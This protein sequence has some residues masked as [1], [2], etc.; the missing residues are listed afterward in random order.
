MRRRKNRVDSNT[1]AIRSAVQK[2]GAIWIDLTGDG[3]VGFD[4]LIAFR[5]NTWL[6]EVKDG[7]KPPSA[8]RLTDTE[9]KRAEQLARVGVTV[10][11]I[12]DEI[13]CLRLIGAIT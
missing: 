7:A 8:R 10:H 2:A 11:V 6:C 13:S 3:S 9:Q 5:G 12:L 4:A 1:Q